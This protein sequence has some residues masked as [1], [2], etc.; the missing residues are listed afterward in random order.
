VIA[1]TLASRRVSPKGPQSGL[2]MLLYFINRAGRGLTPRRRSELEKAKVL[3]SKQLRVRK[4]GKR[5][6]RNRRPGRTTR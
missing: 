4:A 1:R 3:M 5:A 6:G 2:R